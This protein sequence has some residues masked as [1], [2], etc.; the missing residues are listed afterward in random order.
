MSGKTLDLK[1]S[2]KLLIARYYYKQV[3]R[4]LCLKVLSLFILIGNKITIRS[5][6][7]SNRPRS[8]V[9]NDGL[10]NFEKF[11]RKHL[12]WSLFYNQAVCLR[13][14]TLLQKRLRHRCFPVNFSKFFR[15]HFY[16]TQFSSNK[17]ISLV[18]ACSQSTDTN[19][20]II[21]WSKSGKFKINLAGL[22]L[23]FG[24]FI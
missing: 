6:C 22:N 1:H 12:S 9:K 20:F 17:A 15:A 24:S 13:L 8:F 21:A 4:K 10:K 16:R 11:N 19:Y 18:I 5:W 3:I 7:R 23:K 2:W 14:S